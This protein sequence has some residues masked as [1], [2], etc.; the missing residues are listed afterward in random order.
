[1]GYCKMATRCLCVYVCVCVCVCLCVY[2]AVCVSTV[3]VLMFV[4]VCVYV[5]VC[6]YGCVY[7]GVSVC[8]HVWYL[9]FMLILTPLSPP[10]LPPI[11]LHTTPQVFVLQ[12]NPQEP[13][14]Y[15][16]ILKCRFNDRDHFDQE[17]LLSGAGE[18]AVLELGNKV[19]DP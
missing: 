17:L 13:R 19:Q 6:V 10:P 3:H 14:A 12:L 11:A 9:S 7:M 2:V 15:K 8:A 4:R 16:Q 5:W 18:V 1:M